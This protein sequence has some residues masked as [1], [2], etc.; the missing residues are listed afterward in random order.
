MLGEDVA[1]ELH[2][3]RREPLRVMQRRHV[4]LERAE[5]AQV[6][7]TVVIVETLVLDGDERLPHID[8]NLFERQYRAVLDPVLAD[9]PAVG[10]VNLG[11][12]DL[13]IP[14]RADPHDA[15]AP[16][17]GADARPR[18]VRDAASIQQGERGRREHTL[19]LHRLVPP[20]HEKGAARSCG[21]GG[22]R[23][24]RRAIR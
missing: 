10:G 13:R 2:R 21:G 7:D 16:F 11:R 9:E 1:R 12:L 24:R 4:G 18:A 8:G 15:G 17:G 3:D 23:R 6:V 14:L 22:R 5:D 19:A 20:P